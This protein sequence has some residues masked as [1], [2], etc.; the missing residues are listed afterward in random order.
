[1][2]SPIFREHRACTQEGARNIMKPPIGIGLLTV[3]LLLAT[4][5]GSSQ[6]TKAGADSP[7]SSSV[8]APK[9]PNLAFGRT[10]FASTCAVCHGKTGLG[11]GKGPR[12]AKPSTVLSQ[13]GTEPK[14]ELFIAHNMPASNPG[15]LTLIQAQSVALYVW[16]LAGGK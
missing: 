10:V 3:L 5:C 15:S 11:S 2:L 7:H 6:S 8:K 16:K 14:L 12:L 1:M 13:Y 9:T 4:A